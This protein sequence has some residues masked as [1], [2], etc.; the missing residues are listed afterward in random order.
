[1]TTKSDGAPT[2]DSPLYLG[3]Q[4]LVRLAPITANP[5]SALLAAM[6]TNQI[7][8]P[9]CP[10]FVP[11]YHIYKSGKAWVRA[12]SCY[13]AS[14]R[15][16]STFVTHTNYKTP[17]ASQTRRSRSHDDNYKRV[18]RHWRNQTIDSPRSYKDQGLD[19]GV[20]PRTPVFG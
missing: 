2:E 11:R 1:M 16:W 12:M 19:T 4:P 15:S 18:L 6:E 3:K 7:S 10:F 20:L 17:Q 9:V 14:R 13:K 8:N 5:I